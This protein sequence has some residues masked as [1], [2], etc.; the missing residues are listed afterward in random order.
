MRRCDWRKG[1][2][3]RQ[4]GNRR[5]LVRQKQLGEY[6]T[7]DRRE[8]EV[9]RCRRPQRICA[10]RLL[11]DSWIRRLRVPS[12]RRRGRKKA[13][14]CRDHRRQPR[15]RRT[16]RARSSEANTASRIRR[17]T[18]RRSRYPGSRRTRQPVSRR[19]S[20]T[21]ARSSR[22]RATGGWGRVVLIRRR[23]VMVLC[24]RLAPI[25]TRYRVDSLHAGGRLSAT[26]I[27]PS[28]PSCD[29]L[30]PATHRGSRGGLSLAGAGG[31][32]R[33]PG[34][35]AAT[36]RARTCRC[37]TNSRVVEFARIR[38]GDRS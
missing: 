37:E 15:R 13:L 18:A 22:G 17:P 11:D 24:R 29:N 30:T 36:R 4:G 35:S 19:T 14:P 23:V 28:Q 1:G 10:A 9:L 5:H 7:C 34:P 12:G 31:R 6:R 3:W 32:S 27:R 2:T 20:R 38:T 16:W 25:A 21:I 8:R 33:F 26:S